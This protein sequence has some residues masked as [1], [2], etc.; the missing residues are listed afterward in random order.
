MPHLSFLSEALGNS[1]LHSSVITLLKQAQRQGHSF[2]EEELFDAGGWREV[3]RRWWCWVCNWLMLCSTHP[4]LLSAHHSQPDENQSLSQ[5]VQSCSSLHQST[6]I[7]YYSLQSKQ[8]QAHTQHNELP[9]VLQKHSLVQMQNICLL[10]CHFC[11]IQYWKVLPTSETC[12]TFPKDEECSPW[13]LTQGRETLTLTVGL[14]TLQNR[15]PDKAGLL[16]GKRHTGSFGW[17]G[18]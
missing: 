12:W 8:E 18:Q 17:R 14:N 16:K 13:P 2:N 6:K 11:Q 15:A 10:W 3:W 4:A 9:H 5:Q 1:V 7:K